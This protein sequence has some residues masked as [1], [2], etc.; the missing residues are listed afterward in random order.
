MKKLLLFSVLSVF[1]C[2]CS[3]DDD[4]APIDPLVGTWKMTRYQVENA[5]D[6][7]LD[8]TANTDL[9]AE[10]DCYQNETI[11]INADGSALAVSTSYLSIIAEL[12]AGTTNQF[13]YTLDCENEIES[14]P[15]TWT[16]NGTTIAFEEED[17]FAMNATIESN[18]QFTFIIPEGFEILSNDGTNVVTEEDIRIVYTKQ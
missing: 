2:S 5:Y 18:N 6:F 10:V 14:F 12:V 9:L 8:G 17:E 3:S 16:S 1:L 4:A 11:Q 13:T 7:N 15:L